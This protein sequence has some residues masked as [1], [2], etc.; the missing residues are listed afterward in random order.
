[1]A[2]LSGKETFYQNSGESGSKNKQKYRSCEEK[3]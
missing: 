1:V 3:G 2:I